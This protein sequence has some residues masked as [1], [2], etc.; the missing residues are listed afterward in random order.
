MSLKI[1]SK[2]QGVNHKTKYIN[3]MRESTLSR[4]NKKYIFIPNP[5]CTQLVLKVFKDHEI[6]YKSLSIRVTI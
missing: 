6:R 5:F 3:M 2:Q 4:V 1:D